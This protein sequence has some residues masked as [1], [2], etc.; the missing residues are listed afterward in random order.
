MPNLCATIGAALRWAHARLRAAGCTTPVLDAEVLL[1][2]TLQCQRTWLHTH[3]EHRLTES[4]I[5]NFVTLVMR[6]CAHEPVAYLVGH[7]EFFGL[8]FLITPA[9]LVPRP[10]TELLVE[11]ALEHARDRGKVLW[12]ADVGTGSGVLAV[13]LAVHLPR[14]R[15]VATDIS[16][17]AVLL[18]RQNA[19]CHGVDNRILFLQADLLLPV[20]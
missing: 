10:E 1:A 14:A 2:H 5:Q 18:A 20:P 8:D 17:A 6:R 9:V 7:K 15:I 4:Q 3:P 11:I 12:V 13:T 19:Q 16:A